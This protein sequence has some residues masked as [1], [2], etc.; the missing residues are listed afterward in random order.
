V[1][2]AVSLAPAWDEH[3]AWAVDPLPVV[4]IGEAG[5]LEMSEGQRPTE[6]SRIAG[7][8]RLSDGRI[9]VA[10]GDSGEVRF[11]TPDGSFIASAGRRGEGPGEFAV[12]S[13]AGVLPGDSVWVYDFAM[14]R[15]TFFGPDATVARLA[16]LR[17][18]L[19]TLRA[20]G[21]AADG[22][23]VFAQLWAF[24]RTD[25][26]ETFGLR[27]DPA[28]V[29][30]YGTDGVMIDTVGAFPGNEV[31]IREEK[32]RLTMP[33]PLFARASRYAVGSAGLV[34]GTQE[35]Y[36]LSLYGLDGALRMELRF[37]GPPLDVTTQQIR[38][39]IE[40]R[41]EEVPDFERAGLRQFLADLDVPPTRPAYGEILID[42]SGAIWVGPSTEGA[43]EE[44]RW[45]VFDE[46]G[47]W[48]GSVE[49]PPGFDPRMI[50]ADE[51]LGVSTDELGIERVYA[52]RLRRPE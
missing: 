19:P 17:P 20:V 36:A 41:V 46:E 32:G 3:S 23:F 49:L 50:G 16:A 22:S 27:R 5:A 47:R 37:P 44:L 33:R 35:E 2:I 40:Q 11:F 43:G 38:V 1:R 39:A 45:R 18:E 29:V 34:V 52:Y 15:L 42:A 51:L 6:F 31:V 8:V 28:S 21:A 10:D 12:M 24:K 7:V 26:P 13:A 30:R 9:V 25:D 4:E 48:L 14:R